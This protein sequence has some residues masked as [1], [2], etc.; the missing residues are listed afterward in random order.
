M[1]HASFLL[2]CNNFPRVFYNKQFV[3]CSNWRCPISTHAAS[4]FFSRCLFEHEIFLHFKILL[5]VD[6]LCKTPHVSSDTAWKHL[7]K[8]VFSMRQK[9]VLVWNTKQSMVVS[10]FFSCLFWDLNL[11][12]HKF[13]NQLQTL[14][15]IRLL[16]APFV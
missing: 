16:S 11:R 15:L 12:S 8:I 5:R 2:P 4:I 10:Y 14:I 6:L 3:S 1:A 13:L 7:S 9:N